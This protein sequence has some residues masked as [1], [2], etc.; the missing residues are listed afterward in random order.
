MSIS[1]FL[2][3]L[4][5]LPSPTQLGRSDSDSLPMRDF[6]S[7]PGAYTWEDWAEEVRRL[8]P[9]RYFIS[10]TV[11][12]ELS[13]ARRRAR[14]ALYWLKCHTLPK[15][16]AYSRIDIRRPG[17]GID[18][19]YGWI[20]RSE[21]LLYAAFVCLRDF[22][23]NEHPED[24]AASWTLE[25][26]EADDLLKGQK[27]RY[28]EVMALYNWWMKGRLDEDAEEDRLHAAFRE[29]R[30]RPRTD[31][32]FQETSEAWTKYRLWRQER[33]DEML[34]RLVKVRGSLWT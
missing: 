33:E 31:E 27:E 3:K 28:D 25:E 7:E 26:I 10:E 18:Y 23:E 6:G 5:G 9:V 29:V 30:D 20:D 1:L 16:R 15:Y 2:R 32:A 8:H 14:D 24:P 13:I 34:L 17:P 12:L 11:G 21:A 19:S 22:V 4:V